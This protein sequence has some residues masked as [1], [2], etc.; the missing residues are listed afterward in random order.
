MKL[1]DYNFWS[2]IDSLNLKR[3]LL[4][5]SR[6]DKIRTLEQIGEALHSL[7]FDGLGKSCNSSQDVARSVVEK[8]RLPLDKHSKNYLVFIPLYQ[9]DLVPQRYRVMVV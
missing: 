6:G 2:H 3:K 4:G 9:E 7:G 1:G 8:E 5:L